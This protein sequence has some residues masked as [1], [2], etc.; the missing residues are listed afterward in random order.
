MGNHERHDD[1][2]PK[3]EGAETTKRPDGTVPPDEAE[4][5]RLPKVSRGHDIPAEETA[6][7]EEALKQS[8]SV[9]V[10]PASGIYPSSVTIRLSCPEEAEIRYTLDG[11]D[12]DVSSPLYKPKDG[13][14]LRASAT[15]K[16]RAFAEGRGPGPIRSSEYEVRTAIWQENE[17]EDRSDEVEHSIAEES[18]NEG[19]RLAAASVRGKLH[20]HRALWR[21]DAFASRS[22]DGWTVL[23]VSDGAGSALLSR[24]GARLACEAAVTYLEE[25]LSSLALTS[26]D[27]EGLKQDEMPRLLEALGGAAG[28]AL[29]AIR[30]EAARRERLPAEFAATLLV[31]IHRPWRGRHLVGAVQVGDGAV[32]LLDWDGGVTLLGIPDHGE[33]S[34][35][36]RFLTTRG[37]EETFRN[38]VLFSIKDRLRCVAVMSDGVSDDF[39]PENRRLVELLLGEDLPGMRHRDG[40]PMGGVMEAVTGGPE[41]AGAL[42][43]W[44]G[45][46][47]RGSSDD[48]TLMLFWEEG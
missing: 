2:M 12:P 5:T 23:A 25:H 35:E 37:V 16:A 34:A 27:E 13:L 31:T 46:E 10:I 36:T 32:A 41:A 4:T 43:K 3:A 48:R 24:V 9:D 45:Y 20:A 17:P 44:L 47:K 29:G 8:G 28:A 14:L 33:H 7:S 21:E 30:D 1:R 6:S 38:R 42:L 11:S 22:V 40:G 18:G 15:L 19:W 39:F 26:D